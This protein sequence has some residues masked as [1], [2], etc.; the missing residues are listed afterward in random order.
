MSVHVSLILCLL[1]KERRLQ[2][3]GKIEVSQSGGKAERKRG[4]D[5]LETGDG[6]WIDWLSGSWKRLRKMVEYERSRRTELEKNMTELEKIMKGEFFA[7]LHDTTLENVSWEIPLQDMIRLQQGISEDSLLFHYRPSEAEMAWSTPC[8]QSPRTPLG[9]YIPRSCYGVNRREISASGLKKSAALYL[10]AAHLHPHGKTCCD[11]FGTY[12]VIPFRL[13]L[14]YCSDRV[15][16]RRLVD[17]CLHGIKLRHS[18]ERLTNSGFLHSFSNLICFPS[19]SLVLD[20]QP[21]V[22][23]IPLVRTAEQIWNYKDEEMR[24]IILPRDETIFSHI[25]ANVAGNYDSLAH[26]HPD[27]EIA[28]RVF[29]EVVSQIMNIVLSAPDEENLSN[30]KLCV[31]IRTWFRESKNISVPVPL[32]TNTKPYLVMQ[33]GKAML[34]RIGKEYPPYDE[35]VGNVLHH[36]VDPVST[37]MKGM[38]AVTNFGFDNQKFPGFFV[39]SKFV[40]RKNPSGCNIFP[41]CSDEEG[42]AACDHVWAE[43]VLANSCLQDFITSE[44]RTEL[45]DVSCG[46]TSGHK[47]RKA[48]R[49]L[50]VC[51]TGILVLHIAVLTVLVQSGLRRRYCNILA[52][53]R[54]QLPLLNG[55]ARHSRFA[56]GEN[57]KTG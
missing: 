18:K 17:S 55:T 44:M 21:S 4:I 33:L 35:V 32:A 42:D 51:L 53:K 12:S 31:D 38:N 46:E 6:S 45:F 1:I 8:R 2:D 50:Q 3:E 15:E 11:H 22:C 30:E 39:G 57:Y 19:Q 23:F 9:R 14:S 43:R 41:G 16:M 13:K 29:G 37:I 54:I 24:Y 27:V 10:P 47:M 52:M 48:I 25:M 5:S 34:P 7:T 40:S 36:G 28:F 49:L 26:D 56:G 20:T